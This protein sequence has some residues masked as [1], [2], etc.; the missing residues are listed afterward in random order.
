MPANEQSYPGYPW[1]RLVRDGDWV[2]FRE[3]EVDEYG[4][5]TEHCETDWMDLCTP[6]V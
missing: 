4:T 1:T 3:S 6:Q 2:T 5:Y